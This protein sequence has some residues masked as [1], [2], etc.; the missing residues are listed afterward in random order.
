MKQ[1]KVLHIAPHFG[2]GIGT[3]IRSLAGNLSKYGIAHQLVSLE[4]MNERMSSWCEQKHISVLQ[5]A[6]QQSDRFSLSIA[7]AD[8]VHIHWWNHPL[9]M[10]WMA[11]CTAPPFRSV[12]WTHVNGMHAPQA[13][14]KELFSFSDITALATPYSLESLVV[15]RERSTIRVMQSISEVQ[16]SSPPPYRVKK[17]SD[18]FNIGYVGTVDHIKMHPQFIHLC[19]EANI[20]NAKFI[21]CGGSHEEALRRQVS[22]LGIES[23]FDIRGMVEN[24]SEVLLELDLFGYPL[25]PC[26]YGSGEQVL[27]EA[28]GAGVVPVVLDTG[29]ERFIIKDGYN[30]LIAKTQEEYCQAL[31]YLW[32]NPD[33]R[34]SMSDNARSSTRQIIKTKAWDA[35]Y[36]IYEELMLSPK[37]PHQ[38]NISEQLI[39]YPSKIRFFLQAYQDTP[40]AKCF[41]GGITSTNTMN[42]IFLPGLFSRTRGSPF[43]YLFYF[44]ADMNLR[45]ICDYLL[46]H[47]MWLLKGECS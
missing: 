1:I 39:A 31:S 19:L 38:L 16:V 3:V 28:M 40:L 6:L 23:S 29:C 26:H 46:R 41:I 32:K 30:G 45:A 18:T 10:Q 24:V 22:N 5:H 35:W 4:S 12:L 21:V 2:G 7:E 25:N 14:F 34:K 42:E 13:F 37:R 20:S 8:I 47:K 15:P 9:L 11:T 33:V 17:M 43:H 44:T 36:R 27:L